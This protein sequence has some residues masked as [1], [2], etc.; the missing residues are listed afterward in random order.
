MY[1]CEAWNALKMPL[2]E[3]LKYTSQKQKRQ[4][5]VFDFEVI[6]PRKTYFTIS[7]SCFAARNFG[8]TFAG[9]CI[10]S[11]VRGL[12]PSRAA[13]LET[14]NTPKPATFTCSPLTNILAISSNMPSTASWAAFLVVPSLF[15]S[16]SASHFLSYFIA[17]PGSRTSNYK[18]NT[19][20]SGSIFLNYCQT[21]ALRWSRGNSFEVSLP[22]IKL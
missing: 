18:L 10:F 21:G 7:F 15:M 9:I 2:R 16:H 12:M 19:Y 17:I 11:C 22:G 13:R 4:R 8:A 5:A 20:N 6:F 14:L 1:F 3:N